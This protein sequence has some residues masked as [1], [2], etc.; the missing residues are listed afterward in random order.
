MKA[1][2]RFTTL[3]VLLLCL[4]ASARRGGRGGEQ[5]TARPETI[6]C[7]LQFDGV[8]SPE[9]AAAQLVANASAVV[10]GSARGVDYVFSV[11][12]KTAVAR[13]TFTSSGEVL[14]ASG[15]IEMLRHGGES[16][17]PAMGIFR[18]GEDDAQ[19][20]NPEKEAGFEMS[21][22]DSGAVVKLKCLSINQT[23]V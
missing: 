1:I 10:R 20:G 17:A 12:G 4:P 16:R 22:A 11:R 13:M 6:S 5:Q 7:E 9:S 2:T 23:G 19:D 18:R 14:N 21:H 3:A 15:A 8:A